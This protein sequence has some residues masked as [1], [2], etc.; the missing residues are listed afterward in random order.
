MGEQVEEPTK[1]SGHKGAL[2]KMYC[3]RRRAN[4][5]N[6]KARERK[7]SVEIPFPI[8]KVIE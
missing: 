8:G 6:R 1:F 4:G 7:L 5:E 3:A 2:S